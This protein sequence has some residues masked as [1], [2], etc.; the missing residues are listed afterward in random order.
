MQVRMVELVECQ[1]ELEEAVCGRHLAAYP[2]NAD[3]QFLLPHWT[4]I[5][6]LDIYAIHG[7]VLYP[8]VNS[9]TWCTLM[10]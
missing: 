9:C 3:S 7:V 5:L 4:D 1:D 6:H 10:N 2:P 8:I